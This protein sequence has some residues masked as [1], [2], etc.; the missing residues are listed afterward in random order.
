MTT[1]DA[2]RDPGLRPPEERRGGRPKARELVMRTLYETEITG[3][4][5]SEV[6]ALAFGR[7]R[8]TEDGRD[9]AQRLL[10]AVRRHRRKIDNAIS[11]Q[12]ARWDLTRLGTVER[13]ILRLAAA[14]LI[15]LRDTPVHVVLDEALRLAHRYGDEGAAGLLNGVLDPLARSERRL[16]SK[17]A[18]AG[19]S[20][21]SGSPRG[22]REAGEPREAGDRRDP[23]EGGASGEPG[24]AEA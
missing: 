16:P 12:L 22:A 15:Y 6:L 3:D 9:Y 7:L 13:A 8:L 18:G 5:P 17:A 10:D 4:D 20:G 23:R 19:P 24:N 1:R 2:G 21:L 11:K 14:E